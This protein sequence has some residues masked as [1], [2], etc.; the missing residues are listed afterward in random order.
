LVL[1]EDS[2][3][4]DGALK[5]LAFKG[6]FALRPGIALGLCARALRSLKFLLIFQAK[7]RW[8]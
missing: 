5:R 6:G 2:T 8:L 1:T 3:D 4:F 7:E